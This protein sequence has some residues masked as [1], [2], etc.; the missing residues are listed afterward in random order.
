MVSV[1]IPLRSTTLART[2]ILQSSNSDAAV[3][4][5][6]GTRDI[7][8]TQPADKAVFLNASDNIELADDEKIVLGT[9]GDLE[10]F[11]D[12]TASHIKDAGTEI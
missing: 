6:S 3:N 7:F 8:C 4:W 9:G 12:G 5:T 11:H 10:I 1:R 2:T